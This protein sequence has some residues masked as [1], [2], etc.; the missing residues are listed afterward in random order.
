MAGQNPIRS[1]N[2]NAWDTETPLDDLIRASFVT[3]TRRRVSE[4]DK[5]WAQLLQRAQTEVAQL[6]PLAKPMPGNMVPAALDEVNIELQADSRPAVL[7]L[8][9]SRDVDVSRLLNPTL[10]SQ[11]SLYRHTMEMKMW[12]TVGSLG[13]SFGTV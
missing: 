13:L 8:I 11:I 3:E 12:R 1:T 5:M 2:A 10:S 6:P 4:P 7:S 9:D